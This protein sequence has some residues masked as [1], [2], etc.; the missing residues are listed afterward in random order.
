MFANTALLT[1]LPTYFHRVQDLPMDK[2]GIKGGLVMLLAIIGAPLG[3]YLADKWRETRINSRLVFVSISSL[4]TCGI[5]LLAFGVFSGTAQY[6]LLLL[7]GIGAA[8][9]V[10]GAA[11][12]TQDVVHPGL[13][14]ISY[15]LCVISQ[16]ILGSALGPIFVGVMSD[17][18]GIQIALTILPLSYFVAAACYF[19]G[20]FFYERDLAKV[21]KIEMKFEA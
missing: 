10:P 13:R 8:A 5:M 21:E 9:F 7:G 18:Y 16:H 14:A 15:S 17:K 1:W 12:A 2:A 11:A 6:M 3:G 20:S 19:T 4:F